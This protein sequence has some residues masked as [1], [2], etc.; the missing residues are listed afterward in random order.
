MV[1]EGIVYRHLAERQFD[2]SA[3]CSVDVGLTIEKVKH[4]RCRDSNS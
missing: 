2:V 1:H 4:L 3:D